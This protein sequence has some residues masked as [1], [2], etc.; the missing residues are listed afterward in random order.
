MFYCHHYFPFRVD[1]NTTDDL[2]GS[3]STP[4]GKVQV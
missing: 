4:N 2:L 3:Y 1:A